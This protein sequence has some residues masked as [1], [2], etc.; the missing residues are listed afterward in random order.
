[1]PTQQTSTVHS[2]YEL[3]STTFKKRSRTFSEYSTVPGGDVFFNTRHWKTERIVNEARALKLLAEQT[4][5]PIPRLIQCGQNPDGSMFLEM[6]REDGIPLSEVDEECR[7]PGGVRHNSGGKCNACM[8]IAKANA[9]HFIRTI[10]HPELAK[11]RS[12]T[13]GLNGFVLPPAWILEYDIRSQWDSKTS[14]KEEFI[15]IHGDLGPDNLF[16]DPSTLTVKCVI[17]WENSGYFP[18]QFQK[19]AVDYTAYHALYMD[20]LTISALVGSIEP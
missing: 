19:W 16:M 5:I 4:R 1:M 13:T 10:L 8:D 2:V 7:K 6:S 11:L 9:A 12:N 18:Q 15:F 3:S 20:H 17:D 14:S